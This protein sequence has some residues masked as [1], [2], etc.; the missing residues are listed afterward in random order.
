MT[1]PSVVLHLSRSCICVI[2]AILEIRY[3]P[4]LVLHVIFPPGRT[5]AILLT[6][7]ACRSEVLVARPKNNMTSSTRISMFYP[8]AEGLPSE[9]SLVKR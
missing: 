9:F 6:E 8:N 2:P 7:V 5:R 1:R 3:N 4:I